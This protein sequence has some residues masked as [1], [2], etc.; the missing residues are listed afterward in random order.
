MGCALNL[1]WGIAIHPGADS[2]LLGAIPLLAMDLIV[3]PK[4]QQLI[5][6]HGDEVVCLFI[7]RFQRLLTS[8]AKSAIFF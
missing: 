7:K 3:D 2:I 6:A 8:P 4:R 1:A 5:G